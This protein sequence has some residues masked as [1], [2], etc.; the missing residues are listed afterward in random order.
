MLSNASRLNSTRRRCLNTIG[1]MKASKSLDTRRVL[2]NS[3]LVTLGSLIQNSRMESTNSLG[4]CCMMVVV[5][6]GCWLRTKDDMVT[7]LRN[8]HSKK[9]NIYLPV[10]YV[11][12]HILRNFILVH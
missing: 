8:A 7:H 1:E 6:H 3:L 10:Q 9:I 12:D 2:R 11:Q 5:N 4:T